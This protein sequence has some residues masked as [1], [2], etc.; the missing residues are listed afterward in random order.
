M[1]PFQHPERR[2]PSHGAHVKYRVRT[3]FDL[4]VETECLYQELRNRLYHLLSD[5]AR[6]DLGPNRHRHR[7]HQ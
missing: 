2:R 5:P 3:T 1:L 7:Q 4:V 6:L